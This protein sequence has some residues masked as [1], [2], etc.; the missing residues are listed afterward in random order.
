MTRGFILLEREKERERELSC[1]RVLLQYNA[2]DT[3]L[4]KWPTWDQG[5]LRPVCASSQ[6]DQ[7]LLFSHIIRDG[8][9]Y[10]RYTLD[11]RKYKKYPLTSCGGVL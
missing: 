7:T 11:Y 4:Y 9:T 1:L 8:R 2:L 5:W 10:L 6:S 3:V